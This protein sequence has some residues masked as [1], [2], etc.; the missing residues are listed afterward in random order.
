MQSCKPRLSGEAPRKNHLAVPAVHL[1]E[2]A[3]RLS[4]PCGKYLSCQ[5]RTPGQQTCTFETE[6][7]GPHP[8]LSS[9][10]LVEASK[11]SQCHRSQRTCL[12]ILGVVQCGIARWGPL[13]SS[14]P[15][16]SAK[17]HAQCNDTSQALESGHFLVQARAGTP[18]SKA[19]SVHL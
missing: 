11:S 5:D 9:K 16:R 17:T 3:A 8:L 13:S 10:Q 6:L 2:P 18:I 12:G 15:P 19:S 1:V 7:V 4:S 14:E